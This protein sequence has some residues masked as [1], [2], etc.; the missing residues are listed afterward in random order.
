MFCKRALVQTR[1]LLAGRSHIALT[2]H[3][4]FFK[5]SQIAVRNFTTNDNFMSGSNANYIDYMYDCWKSDPKSVNASWNAYFASGTFESPP[6]LG[7]TPR[8]A[9]LDEILNL[10]KSGAGA[11]GS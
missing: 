10:L 4:N 1:F 3:K 5:A 9:Q 11:K 2:A 8:D 6:T 7:Q